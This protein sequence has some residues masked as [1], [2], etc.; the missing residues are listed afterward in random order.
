MSDSDAEGRNR[1]THSINAL[2]RLG[3]KGPEDE[4]FGAFAR[5]LLAIRPSAPSDEERKQ[6]LE[7]PASQVPP[8]PAPPAPVNDVTLED[9]ERRQTIELRE[10]YARKAY[11]FVCKSVYLLFLVVGADV[12]FRVMFHG[13]SLVIPSYRELPPAFSGLDS[14]VLIALISGVTVNV[15]AVFIVVMRNL[16]PHGKTTK[17]KAPAAKRRP[18]WR[19]SAEID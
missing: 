8:S 3:Q 15:V 12:F 1:I 6:A 4:Q 9:Q 14:K 17:K 2:R 19:R 7:G 13:Y 18:R 16:F 10:R 11:R 5:A